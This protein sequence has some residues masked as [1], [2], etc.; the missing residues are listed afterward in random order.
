MWLHLVRLKITAR[1]SDKFIAPL[2]AIELSRMKLAAAIIPA[3][4]AEPEQTL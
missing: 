2:L 3:I 4:D 1:F